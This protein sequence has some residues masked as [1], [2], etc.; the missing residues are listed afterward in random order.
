MSLQPLPTGPHVFHF[1]FGNTVDICSGLC[2]PDLPNTN[3]FLGCRL[4][5]VATLIGIPAGIK[6]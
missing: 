2:L 5:V 3:H 6:D 1:S 4:V